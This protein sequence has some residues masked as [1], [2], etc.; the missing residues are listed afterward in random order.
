MGQTN[1]N[2]YIANGSE[3]LQIATQQHEREKQKEEHEFQLQLQKQQHDHENGLKEKD[4]GWRGKIFGGEKISSKNITA[5]VCSILLIGVIAFS[6]VIYCKDANDKSFIGQLWDY[7]L[8]I[9]TL[10]LGYLF[11]KN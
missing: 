8:P 2:N 10:S 4:L 5:F 6:I 11:G 1:K 9:I 3:N 7:V